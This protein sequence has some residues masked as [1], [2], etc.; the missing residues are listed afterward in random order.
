M[1]SGDLNISTPYATPLA[2]VTA[3]IGGLQAEITYAGA[4]PLAPVGVFQINVRIPTAVA[5]GNAPVNV[6]VGG[7]VTTQRV[8]VA[9][10]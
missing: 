3:T 4:A 7:I 8:T 9:V 6:S 5:A 1:L 10:R 2:P